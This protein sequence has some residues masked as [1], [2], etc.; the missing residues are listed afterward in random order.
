MILITDGEDNGGGVEEAVRIAKGKGVR[1]YVLGIGTGTPE[2]VPRYLTDGTQDGFM[3]DSEGSYVTT[4]LSPEGEE[5]L[6]QVASST[7]GTYTRSAPGKISLPAVEREIRKLKQSELKARKVTIYDEFYL[8]F[9]IPALVL[10]VLETL[11]G[12]ARTPLGKLFA[13]RRNGKEER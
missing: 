6:K 12:D 9:L 8:W 7:G 3:R 13:F 10:L 2:L 5:M 11:P 4:S 1:I